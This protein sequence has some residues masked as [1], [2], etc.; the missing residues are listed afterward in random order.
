MH[1]MHFRGRQVNLFDWYVFSQRSKVSQGS[2]NYV[3][4]S[5]P[6]HCRLF[7]QRELSHWASSCWFFQ[8]K[9]NS[10]EPISVC[11]NSFTIIYYTSNS[12]KLVHQTIHH[13]HFTYF[14]TKQCS[15][16]I[17]H[18]L[19]YDVTMMYTQNF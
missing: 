1:R 11:N 2:G 12:S 16:F 19:K 6:K 7:I 14:H 4:E 8:H 18:T 5:L 3:F 17:K 15:P 9:H 13:L 10:A